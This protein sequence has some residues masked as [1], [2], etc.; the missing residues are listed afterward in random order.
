MQFSISI[1][2]ALEEVP[3]QTSF[4]SLDTN[5]NDCAFLMVKTAGNG[6]PI[7]P[8]MAIICPQ[9]GLAGKS[10]KLPFKKGCAHCNR[11][12]LENHTIFKTTRMNLSGGNHSCLKESCR[13]LTS[14]GRAYSKE[15]LSGKKN[16]QCQVAAGKALTV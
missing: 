4:F 14:H 8:Q 15:G 16:Q 1:S 13:P 5:K 7:T 10:P 6:F 2:G 9:K 11:G 3:G 12:A